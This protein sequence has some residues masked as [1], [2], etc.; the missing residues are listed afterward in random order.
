MKI[1]SLPPRDRLASVPLHIPGAAPAV[2]DIL[3]KYAWFLEM[4][5][6][7]TTELEGHFSDKQ[8]RT[9]MFQR[10]NAYGDSMFK[11][12]QVIDESDARLRLLR[13]LGV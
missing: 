10:A 4:T 9:E 13:N 3:D 6:L 12:L 1:T 11:L 8:K 5:G 7:P 2:N